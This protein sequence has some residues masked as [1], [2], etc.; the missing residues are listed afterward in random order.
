MRGD[1]PSAVRL[2]SDHMGARPSS[3]RIALSL[4]GLAGIAAGITLVWRGMR[5]V[6]DIGGACGSGNTSLRLVQE[7]PEGLGSSMM[8]GIF[9]GLA[10][11]GL[12]VATAPRGGPRP[13]LL[14][15]PALFLSLGWNF[16]DYGFNP[17]DGDGA[18]AGWLI[19]GVIFMLMGGVPLLVVLG[20]KPLRGGLTGAAQRTSG[21]FAAGRVPSAGDLTSMIDVANRA[22]RALATAPA[23][24]PPPSDRAE[25]ADD[26]VTA[27]ERLAELHRDGALDEAEYRAAK[28]RI[29]GGGG[30]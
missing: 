10:G 6:M 18:V 3:V 14:A 17:P 12:H 11:L 25:D 1:P 15:W 9:L 24:P 16:L 7:C 13:W 20:W 30:E 5:A 19:P 26:I 2:A 27:L 22:T 21:A 8:L 4:V 28:E 23:A 29:L